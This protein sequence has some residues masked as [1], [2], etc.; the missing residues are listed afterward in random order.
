MK[1]TNLVHSVCVRCYC[2]A[3]KA[4]LGHAK[5]LLSCL[6]GMHA[7]AN[8]CVSARM[9]AQGPGNLHR[10]PQT[11][12]RHSCDLYGSI[13]TALRSMLQRGC[14]RSKQVHLGA[15]GA[16]LR[17]LV[18]PVEQL[19]PAQV[20]RGGGRSRPEAAAP[21]PVEPLAPGQH[22][23]ARMRKH[24]C[25]THA[26]YTSLFRAQSLHMFW[27]PWGAGKVQGLLVMIRRLPGSS[28]SVRTKPSSQS[29]Q[30]Q[31]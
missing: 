20:G 4:W 29:T 28:P 21:L 25:C 23:P 26:A 24:R 15:G 10:M 30:P 17:V 12:I 5:R 19:L 9:L 8:T 22:A 31:T 6:Q 7:G 3:R 2:G 1:H 14:R 11:K 27:H 13:T 18:P 16:V